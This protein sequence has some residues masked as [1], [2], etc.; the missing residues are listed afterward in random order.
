MSLTRY[1][2][3]LLQWVRRSRS[4]PPTV[5][6]LFRQHLPRLLLPVV[7]VAVISAYE[8]ERANWVPMLC[9]GMLVGTLLERLMGFREIVRAWPAWA[10]VVDF[11]R[12]DALLDSNRAD[13]PPAA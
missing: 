1:E 6:H 13:A 3:E 9:I 4:E 10:A 2:R 12:V 8:W 7:A 11:Q 5:A